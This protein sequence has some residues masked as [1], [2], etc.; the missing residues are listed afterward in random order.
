MCHTRT[1]TIFA[2]LGMH[3]MMM[4]RLGYNCRLRPRTPYTCDGAYARPV[5]SR[6]TAFVINVLPWLCQ[7]VRVCGAAEPPRVTPCR[8]ARAYNRINFVVSIV[9]CYDYDVLAFG[10][11]F[12]YIKTIRCASGVLLRLT[13]GNCFFLWCTHT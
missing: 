3:M 7:R 1:L 9:C 12:R 4:R 2:C 11:A 5:D 13:G 10:V 6:T 8:A